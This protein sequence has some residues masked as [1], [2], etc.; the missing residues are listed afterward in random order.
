MVRR[1][2]TIMG[3]ELHVESALGG[4]SDFSFVLHFPLEAAFLHTLPPPAELRGS[5]VLVVDDNT[6]NRRIV[7]EMLAGAGATVDEAP[8]A[9][10]GLGALHRAHLAGEPYNLAI[11]DTHIPDRGRFELAATGRSGPR[12]GSTPPPM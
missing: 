4:G 11:I 8:T 1:L 10:A 7:R 9:D 2:V 5:R 12:H 6:T 3:G